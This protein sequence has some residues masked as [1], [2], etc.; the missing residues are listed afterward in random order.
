M[1]YNGESVGIEGLKLLRLNL[2][3]QPDTMSNI[4]FMYN[5]KAGEL[6]YEMEL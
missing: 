6:G 3:E 4:E 2:K 5:I 1:K